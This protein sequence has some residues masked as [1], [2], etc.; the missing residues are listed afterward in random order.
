M[1]NPEFVQENGAHKIQWEFEIKTDRL[2]STRPRD[3][4]KKKEKEK[5]RICWIVDFA[6]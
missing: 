6:G 2:I 4:K 1:H 3:I 5:K